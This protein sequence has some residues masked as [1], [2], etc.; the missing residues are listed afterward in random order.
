MKKILYLLSAVALLSACSTTKEAT[1]SG[2][3][4]R[5]EKKIVAQE[6]VKNAVESK[7]F[8]VKLN[9]MYLTY[10][11]IVQ[12]VPRSNYIIVDGEKGVISTA[13]FG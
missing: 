10:G 12:L 3:L 13:Y 5:N 9:R 11:G 7:R 1:S 2:A 8:I 4:T 6:A